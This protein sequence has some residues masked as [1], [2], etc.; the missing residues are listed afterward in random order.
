MA[1]SRLGEVE[2]RGCRVA[3]LGHLLL[4]LLRAGP[5]LLQPGESCVLEL[6]QRERCLRRLDSGAGLVDALFNVVAGVLQGFLGPAAVGRGGCQ[7]SPGDLDVDRDLFA[8]SLQV[9][10][11]ARQLGPC[12]FEL[13][14]ARH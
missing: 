13:G 1:R 10:A 12:C 11:L 4:P 5:L 3:R 6:G 9:G 14:L 7:G 8:S 2:L